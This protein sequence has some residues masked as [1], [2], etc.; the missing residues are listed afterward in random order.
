MTRAGATTT[1]ILSLTIIAF[2]LMS[3][4]TAGAAGEGNRCGGAANIRCD[5][6]VLSENSIRPGF[7]S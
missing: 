4:Q 7:A 1:F 5:D 3:N 2:A 6:G